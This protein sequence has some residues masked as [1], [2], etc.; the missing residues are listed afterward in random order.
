M[1]RVITAVVL[2]PLVLWMVF[3]GPLWLFIAIVTMFMLLTQYEYFQLL[4]SYGLEPWPITSAVVTVA[5]FFISLYGFIT[6]QSSNIDLYKDIAVIS[7]IPFLLVSF[8]SLPVFL[9]MAMRSDDLSKALQSGALSWLALPYIALPYLCLISLKMLSHSMGAFWIT[10]ILLVV[11]GGDIFAMYTGKLIGRNKL[12]PR[13]SPGK[14]WEGTIGSVIGSLLFGGAWFLYAPEKI[15]LLKDVIRHN[16][17][18]MGKELWVICL[19]LTVLTNCAA[20]FG[21]LVES[22]IKRGAGVKDSGSM[23]PGHG[24]MLDRVDA[25]LYAAPVAW[26]YVLLVLGSELLNRSV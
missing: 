18:F 22:M 15:A 20:Q 6:L 23:L 8:S 19:V 10:Y 17:H 24:G 13:I 7:P 4:K 12:A 25:M 14:T 9:I 3:Q 21:D 26:V 1:K 11:W 2:I 16:S 5:G